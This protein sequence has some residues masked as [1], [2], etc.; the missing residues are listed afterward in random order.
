MRSARLDMALH[1]GAL[2]LPDGP[3]AVWRPV[4]GDDLSALGKARVTVLTGFKPDHDHFAA[5]GY[6]VTPAAPYAAGLVCLPRAKALAHDLVAQALTQV[7][8]GGPVVVDGQKTDGID[9]LLKDLRTA[10]VA[11]GE[12]VSKAHGKLVVLTAGPAPDGWAR[13]AEPVGDGFWTA[14]GVFSAEGPDAGS[15]LLAA[16]LPADLPA[17]VGDLGAGWGYLT[18]AILARPGVKHLDA[19]EAEASAL[20]CARRAI[21][22]PRVTWAWA[23]ARTF[24]PKH[25]WGAVVMNPPFH[26]GRTAE[27][28]LGIGFIK[29]AHAGLAPDGKLWLVANRQLPYEPALKALFRKV[30]PVAQSG[31]YKVIRAEAPIRQR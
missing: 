27:P 30:E 18:R 15:A 16:H 31:V 22:D 9:S 10:G 13:G 23:D 8:P 1:S 5:L 3:V 28:D 11:M 6:A 17:K 14:P 24:R 7:A 29:A 4:M 2:V 25:L 19:V 26:T 12:P 21:D 20:D